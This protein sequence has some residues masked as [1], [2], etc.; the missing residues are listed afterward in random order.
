MSYT[1]LP[2][3]RILTD[4]HSGALERGGQRGRSAERPADPTV[5]AAMAGRAGAPGVQRRALRCYTAVPLLEHRVSQQAGG[6]H[7]VEPDATVGRE[8]RRLR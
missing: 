2:P 6:V 1:R 3:R 5:R 8:L 4:E 7:P